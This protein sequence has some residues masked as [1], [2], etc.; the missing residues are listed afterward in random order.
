MRGGL[1]KYFWELVTEQFS[2]KWMSGADFKRNE[3]P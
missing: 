3:L 2:V 1:G